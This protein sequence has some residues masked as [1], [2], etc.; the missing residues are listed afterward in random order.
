MIDGKMQEV[1][2][3]DP[4]AIQLANLKIDEMRNGFSELVCATSHRN[5]RTGWLIA[6]TA[7][8]TVLC[9]PTMTVRTKPFRGLT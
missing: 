7:P 4:E 1:K 2:V 8:S 6:T 3:R 5:L 9:V